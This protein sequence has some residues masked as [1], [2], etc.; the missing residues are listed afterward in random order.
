MNPEGWKGRD[1]L[2]GV[3]PEDTAF[4]DIIGTRADVT[5]AREGDVVTLEESRCGEVLRRRIVRVVKTWVDEKAQ[6]QIEVRDVEPG[7][8][9][10]LSDIVVV[11]SL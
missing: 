6:H 11:V 5:E 10:T 2:E 8:P 1:A 4:W 3:N 7:E 9:Y